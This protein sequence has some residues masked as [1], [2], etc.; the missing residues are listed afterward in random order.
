MLFDCGEL[1][2]VAAGDSEELD[3]EHAVTLPIRSIPKSMV[4]IVRFI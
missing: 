3:W 1:I 4:T 2:V